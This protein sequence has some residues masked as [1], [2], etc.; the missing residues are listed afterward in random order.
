MRMTSTLLSAAIALGSLLLVPGAAAQ[1][2]NV[3]RP[4][5]EIEQLLAAEPMATSR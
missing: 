3:L 4:V 1:D 2:A 5:A